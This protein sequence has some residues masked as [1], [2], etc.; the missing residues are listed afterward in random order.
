MSKKYVQIKL[1]I[2]MTY[3]S[4]SVG[5]QNFEKVKWQ[6][7]ILIRILSEAEKLCGTRETKSLDGIFL[8]KVNNGNTRTMC[9]ISSELKLG[10]LQNTCALTLLTPILD[11]EK[12]LTW[13]FHVY[14]SSRCLKRFYEG[15]HKNLLRYHKEVWK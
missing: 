15:L 8:F 6:G 13:N 10:R 1:Y 9:E 12:K 11:K 3:C 14:T 2:T 5:K 4:S 7:K